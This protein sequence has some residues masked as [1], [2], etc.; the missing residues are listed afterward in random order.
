MFPVVADAEIVNF[1]GRFSSETPHRFGVNIIDT[2]E[3]FE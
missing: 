3:G 2:V 1:V